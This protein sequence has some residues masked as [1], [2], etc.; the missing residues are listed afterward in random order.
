MSMDTDG[1]F[2]FDFWAR[3]A[4]QD[5]GAF[6]EARRLMVESLIESAPARVQPRL[7]GLQWQIDQVRRRAPNPLSACLKLSNMMWNNVLG[8]DGLSENLQSL[9]GGR[10]RPTRPEATVLPLRREGGKPAA[11]GE[12]APLT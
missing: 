7:K 9:S 1:E 8:E 3:L 6:E 10:Q 2:P 12:D 11:P 4:Q 5:P